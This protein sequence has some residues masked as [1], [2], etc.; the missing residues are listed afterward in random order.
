MKIAQKELKE[1]NLAQVLAIDC[2]L[3]LADLS[4]KLCEMIEK[5]APFGMGNPK[6][7]FCTRALRLVEMRMVG[8]NSNHLKIKLDDPQTTKIEEVPAF[9]GIGFGMGNLANEIK[10][11][12]LIDIVYT[13]EKNVWNEEERLELKIKDLR[14]A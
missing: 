4:W 2:E 12:D 9:D 13:L 10:P 14:L 5:F 11:R 7:V 6:P 8:N 3:R 1:E